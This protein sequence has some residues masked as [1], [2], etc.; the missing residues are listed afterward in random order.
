MGSIFSLMETNTKAS[1]RMA[2]STEK[3]GVLLNSLGTIVYADGEK[4]EGDWT[5]W[6]M[7]GSGN[8]LATTLRSLHI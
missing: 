2:R 7:N 1:G 4:Y 3:V 6:K 5:D 8:F